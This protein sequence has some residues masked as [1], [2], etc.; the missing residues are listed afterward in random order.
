M[1]F[2]DSQV[3]S[4]YHISHTREEIQSLTKETKNKL[5]STLGCLVGLKIFK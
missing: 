4:M 1:G 5:Y 2:G 3:Y